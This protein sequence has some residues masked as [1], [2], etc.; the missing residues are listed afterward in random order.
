MIWSDGFIAGFREDE[1][2][3]GSELKSVFIWKDFT[4]HDNVTRL[5]KESKLGRFKN[6]SYVYLLKISWAPKKV[7][8]AF[9]VN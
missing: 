7:L 3:V 8:Q 4:N 6:S 1:R 5:A 2:P 9:L